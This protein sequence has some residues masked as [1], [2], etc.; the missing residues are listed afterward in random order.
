MK[1]VVGQAV[2]GKDFWDRKSEL[3]KIWQAIENGTHP[4]LVAPR[5]VGKTSIMY[6][7]LDEPKENY[8]VV[9]VNTESAQS[10]N[11]FWYK[12]FNALMDEEF[13]NKNSAKFKNFCAKLK[14]LNIES[15]SISGSI[16]LGDAKELNYAEAFET[17]IKDIESD[18]KLIIMMDEFA[19]TIENI[20]KN[21]TTKEAE[22]LLSTHRT[23]RQNPKI[24]SKISF[25]Y[26]GSIGLESVVERFKAMKFINDLNS[27]KITP[28]PYGEAKAFVRELFSHIEDKE[29]VYLLE[30][31]EWLIPFYIQLIIQ[32]LNTLYMEKVLDVIGKADIDEAILRAIGSK[33]YFDHWRERIQ[34][35]FEPS[36]FKFA[37]EILN[38]LS[39]HGTL[40]SKEISNF[41]DKYALLHDQAKEIIHALVYDGYIN[42]DEN[43]KIYRFNS[44]ILKLWWYKNVAN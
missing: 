29:I 33:N 15:I 1:N 6:K 20:V 26:A 37:K 12:L 44:P 5:R 18:K 10:A 4:L 16:K 2:R 24:A 41:A 14:T 30:R 40:E 38:Q 23:L 7:I 27:I 35:A 8:A 28:L 25:I 9:Y 31:I 32:E 34:A 11:E 19:Q 17:L 42:N 43:P 3:A 22:S 13:N 21:A 36:E 39:E